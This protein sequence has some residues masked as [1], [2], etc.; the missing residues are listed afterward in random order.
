MKRN[1][2]SKIIKTLFSAIVI[3]AVLVAAVVYLFTYQSETRGGML[4]PGKSISINSNYRCL[5]AY[6]TLEVSAP[7]KDEKIKYY[8]KNPSN[9]ILDQGEFDN[10]SNLILDKKYSGY[11]GTWHIEFE[12]LPEGETLSYKYTFKAMNTGDKDKVK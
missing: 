6:L 4:E 9:K 5:K 1:T 8:I 2:K 12:N 3:T 7:I 10:K 11:K